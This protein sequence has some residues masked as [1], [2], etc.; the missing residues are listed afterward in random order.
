MNT[1]MEEIVNIISNQFAD[2]ITINSDYYSNLDIYVVNEQYFNQ[3]KDRKKNRIYVVVKFLAPSLDFNQTVFPIELQAISE[4]NGLEICQNLL[5][6]FAQKYNLKWDEGKIV[7]QVYSGPSTVSNFNEIFEGFRTLF[8]MSGAFIITKKANYLTVY[9]IENAENIK[10]DENNKPVKETIKGVYEFSKSTE[11]EDIEVELISF[12]DK[13]FGNG[14]PEDV[15]LE[16]TFSIA[17][18]NSKNGDFVIPSDY[19]VFLN[20]PPQ[21]GDKIIIDYKEGFQEIDAITLSSVCDINLD[22]QP[23]YNS[24]G[25]GSSKPKFGIFTL[26]ITTYLFDNDFL[27]KCLDV[28][29]NNIEENPTGLNTDFNIFLEFKNGKNKLCKFKLGNCSLTE[30]KG[31]LAL[32]SLTFT[33]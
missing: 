1:L 12:K 5:Y 23:F 11:E 32:V 19:G 21:V 9:F 13:V 26:N 7:Q 14:K 8:S 3:I 33:I 16:F 17:G 2:I 31:E 10:Y 29:L 25:L 4:E 30:A 22:T 28:Y 15:S 27:N 18:W 24:K 6:E 20:E